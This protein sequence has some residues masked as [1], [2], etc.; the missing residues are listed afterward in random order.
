[1]YTVSQQMTA[2][3]SNLSDTEQQSNTEEK[4][5]VSVPIHKPKV[6]PCRKKRFDNSNFQMEI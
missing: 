4:T 6:I 5:N 1:M 3:D 2:E